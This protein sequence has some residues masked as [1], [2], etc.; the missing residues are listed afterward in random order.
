LVPAAGGKKTE[1][2]TK[3]GR[4]KSK[5]ELEKK[6]TRSDPVEKGGQGD[7]MLKRKL[8]FGGNFECIPTSHA[9][10]RASG[11]KKRNSAGDA[12][13]GAKRGQLQ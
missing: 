6:N 10:V 8:S 1:I 2:L 13:R 5:E 12:S 3:R 7:I 11:H 9:W 4:F